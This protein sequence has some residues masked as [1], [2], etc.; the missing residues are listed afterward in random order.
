VA[1]GATVTGIFEK[2]KIS[3]TLKFATKSIYKLELPF[4]C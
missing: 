4:S 1:N 2:N 3:V